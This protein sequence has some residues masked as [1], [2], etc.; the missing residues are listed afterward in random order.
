MRLSM[1]RKETENTNSTN[2]NAVITAAQRCH[3][4]RDIRP[5]ISAGT[6]KQ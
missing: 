5:L 4:V 3:I 6:K 1:N 2:I